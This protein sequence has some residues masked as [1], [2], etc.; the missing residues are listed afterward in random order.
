MRKLMPPTRGD[1]ENIVSQLYFRQAM[2]HL[3]DQQGWIA[4]FMRGA[5]VPERDVV[6]HHEPA[7]HVPA[8]PA[9]IPQPPGRNHAGRVSA[10]DGVHEGG[11]IERGQVVGSFA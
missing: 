2:A 5:G 9:G 4:A 7:G 11:G 10:E 8:E 1:F 6:P 3:E